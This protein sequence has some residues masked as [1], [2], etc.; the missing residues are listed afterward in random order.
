MSDAVE[1]LK[2]MDV[3]TSRDEILDAAGDALAARL[4]EE[5]KATVSDP[6]IFRAH[7]AR[8]EQEFTD[9]MQSLNIRPPTVMTRVS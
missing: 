6:E 3:S 4:D 5:R 9:D 2:E 1:R 8:F 7:A